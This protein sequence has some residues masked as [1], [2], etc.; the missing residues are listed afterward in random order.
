MR[1]GKYT[2]IGG[3]YVHQSALRRAVCVQYMKA[4]F[5]ALCVG[6]VGAFAYIMIP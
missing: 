1:Q 6:A 4:I 2:V 5:C 3:K